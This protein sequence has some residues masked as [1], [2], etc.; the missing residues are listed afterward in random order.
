[1]PKKQEQI[2]GKDK[3]VVLTDSETKDFW[4]SLGSTEIILNDTENYDLFEEFVNEQKPSFVAALEKVNEIIER[5][6]LEGKISEYAKWSARIKHFENALKNVSI[7]QENPERG[8]A[9]DDV[10]GVRIIG[11]SEAELTIIQTEL[12]KEF[13]TTKKKKD[14]LNTLYNIQRISEVSQLTYKELSKKAR[15]GNNYSVLTEIF[16]SVEGAM[17]KAM[18]VVED[19]YEKEERK[20]T[21]RDRGY[22]ARHRYYYSNEAE[23]SPL[24]EFQYWTVELDY[25]CTYGALSYSNY[26]EIS[27][28]E[29]QEMYEQ[30]RFRLGNNISTIYESKNGRV[31]KLSSEEALKKTYPFLNMNKAKKQDASLLKTSTSKKTSASVAT[32]KAVSLDE[33]DDD[34]R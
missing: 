7:N 33:S 28:E 27:K 22:N 25:Q 19:V 26:K 5:L 31:Y 18:G 6:K 11:A 21:S 34:E 14:S 24:I 15:S 3:G 17:I 2:K 12:E 30:G 29:I 23:Y 1:M 4:R 16:K 32:S 13:S 10:F 9:L 8:N 20:K